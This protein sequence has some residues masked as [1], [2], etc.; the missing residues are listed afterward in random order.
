MTAFLYSRALN[1][2]QKLVIFD[3]DG[4]LLDSE[5]LYR[6][7]NLKFFNELGA[8]ISHAEYDSF[9]GIA[10]STMWSRIKEKAPITHSV[11]TLKSMERELKYSMLLQTDLRPIAGIP[12]F[13]QA[14]KQGGYTLA[15]ASSGQRKNIEL[16]L[17]KTGLASCFAY[18]VSGEQ[19]PRGKPEP[20]I[21]LHVAHHFGVAPKNCFVV[22]DSRNG[23]LAAKAAGMFCIGFQNPGS[24]SQD[25]H[26]ADLVITGFH[27]KKLYDLFPISH[28][29]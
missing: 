19:V 21:F 7:T 28:R 15:V 26:Q 29:P 23:V 16:I 2:M 6:E 25:L 3:M 4:V 9:I 5:P 22:E 18:V 12:Q 27:D 20:D 14:L 24:G 10:A 17:Q 13:L 1:V 11:E 8:H